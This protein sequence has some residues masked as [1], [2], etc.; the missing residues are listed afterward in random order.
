MG[1]LVDSSVL[2]TLERRGLPVAV[3]RDDGQDDEPWG[4]AAITVSELLFGLHRAVTAI[5]RERRQAFIDDILAEF[6]VLA[7]DEPAAVIHA[8]I[9][10]D[11]AA[12]GSRIG[13]HDFLIA[14]TALRH[15][16]ALLTDNVREF[17][18]VVGLDVRLP[19]W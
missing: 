19:N 6:P 2:I 1:V 15:S 8:R 14:A 10:S 18:R 7:F 17:R 13:T 5:Q 12:A 9:W 16:Y 3:L 11:L 4:I